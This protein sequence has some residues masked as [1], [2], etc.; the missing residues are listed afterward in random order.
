MTQVIA[1]P[2]PTAASAAEAPAGT[3]TPPRPRL[4]AL[5]IA[6]G[7]AIGAMV[8]ID[9]A[10]SGAIPAPFHHATYNGFTYADTIFPLFM[11]L[12]GVSMT[13]SDRRGQFRPVASRTVKLIAISSVLIAF[14]YDHW[15]NF[16]TGVLQ[17]IGVAFF[18]TWLL[19]RLPIRYQRIVIGGLLAFVVACYLWVPAASVLPGQF[20][21]GHTI[22]D[23]FDRWTHSDGLHAYLPSIASVYAGVEVGR[24]LRRC[25]G[26]R[27]VVRLVVVGLALSAA[28]LALATVIPLNKHLW[29]PSFVLLGAGLATLAYLVWHL[30]VGAVGP[31]PFG[32]LALLGRNAIAIYIFDELV[33]RELRNAVWPLVHGPLGNA[34]GATA[35]SF[36]F[37]AFALATCAGLCWT[38]ER[39][40]IRL[41]L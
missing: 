14:K 1:T 39:F 30:V 8:L 27:L 19:L 13:L 29:T 25:R 32:L 16:D 17:Q 4:D 9:M 12:V 5:D 2:T 11:L 36:V 40:D 37:P 21:S 7:Y 31:R 3:A 15:F 28:G 20:V 35:T 41:R 24:L 10:G 34:I 6:R 38:M 18:C 33:N 26:R 22:G 23:A